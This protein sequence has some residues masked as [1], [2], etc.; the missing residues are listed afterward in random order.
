MRKRFSSSETVGMHEPATF[1]EEKH[2]SHRYFTMSFCENSIVAETSYRQ[3]SSFIIF[4]S[5]KGSI[6]SNKNNFGNFVAHKE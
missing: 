1:W 5:R 6:G 4:Q 2:D 3:N